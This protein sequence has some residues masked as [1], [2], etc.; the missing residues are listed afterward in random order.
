MQRSRQQQHAQ[1]ERRDG[2]RQA[3]AVPLAHGEGDV[4]VGEHGVEERDARRIR[5]G[6][7]RVARPHRRRH[8]RGIDR[9]R[10]DGARQAEG[11]GERRA[12]VLRH[13]ERPLGGR[14]ADVPRPGGVD[15]GT[16]VDQPRAQLARHE[17]PGLRP[18]ESLGRQLGRPAAPRDRLA[19]G[20]VGGD[21]K[22]RRRQAPGQRG[23]GAQG[24]LGAIEQAAGR[25]G[26]V[27]DRERELGAV[28]ERERHV[29]ERPRHRV[30][31]RPHVVA[32]ALARGGDVRPDRHAADQQP[33]AIDQR[34]ARHADR[35]DPP[36]ASGRQRR[37]RSRAVGEKHQGQDSASEFRVPSSRF[38]VRVLGSRFV[39]W[40]RGSVQGSGFRFRVPSATLRS[41]CQHR[42][43]TPNTNAEAGT[44]NVELVQNPKRNHEP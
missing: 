44:W 12:D 9:D 32:H 25:H 21:G 33:R 14:R 34:A 37:R 1:R 36:Q 23:G 2:Q 7:H 38:R 41:P 3:R 13:R 29:A 27:L 43:G 4:F 28:G 19:L 11:E 20:G 16:H 42:T 39:F 10:R 5:D 18:G 26:V 15:D 30:E 24:R 8:R 35:Q 17:E 31:R 22:I 6:D 40:V